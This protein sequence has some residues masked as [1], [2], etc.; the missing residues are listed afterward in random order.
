MSHKFPY[1]WYLKDG[2]PAKGIEYHGS[3]VFGTFIC[4][5]GSSMGYKLAGFD[6]LGGVE[7]DPKVAE[8][9]M[10]NHKPKHLYVEDIRLFNQRKDLPEELYHLDLLDGSPPCSSFSMAGNRDKD[11]GKEKQFREGQAHQRLDDLVF[12]YVKTI[13]KLQPKV[14]LLENVKGLIQGNAKAY[15]KK[16]NK[17]FTKAGYRVQLFLLNAASM[18]VPQKRERVFFI[19]LRN[20]ID[21][22]KLVLDFD[23]SLI[24][25]KQAT[26][27]IENLFDENV[28]D[29]A[30]KYWKTTLP[31][32]S[33]SSSSFFNWIR[34]NENDAF[35]TIA[36]ACEKLHHPSVCR[37]LNL[38]EIKRGGTYPCDFVFAEIKGKYLIGMSVPPVMTAQIVH[39]IWLQWLSKIEKQTK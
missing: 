10:L 8:V 39:Q 25:F 2:Y 18:G 32:K 31:G 6:H 24:T 29:S 36:S 14:A 23:E 15:A 20:D 16:I 1:K 3:K 22:P 26:N 28:T 37:P 35:P 33:F 19:G 7:I 38:E 5:G 34:L 11:W 13:K 4:G 17:E 12:E 27:D 9:Y 30:L 21:L